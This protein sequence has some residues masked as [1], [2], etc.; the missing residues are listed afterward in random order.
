MSYPDLQRKYGIS[1]SHAHYIMQKAGITR[2]ES[3]TLLFKTGGWRKLTP[4]WGHSIT[5]ILSLPG[6]II[7]DLGFDPSDKL[8]GKWQILGKKLILKIRRVK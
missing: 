3:E 7:R 4:M 6:S 2:N 1:L 8:E 5:R